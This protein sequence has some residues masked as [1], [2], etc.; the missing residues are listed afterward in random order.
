MRRSIAGIVVQNG[1]IL[2]A[3]RKE[4]G[5]IGLRW[6]FPG[7]KV[8]SGEGDEEA[9]RREFEEE[10]GIR[11]EPVRCLGS[12]SFVSHSGE[13]L[14]T[15][16]LVELPKDC[17]LELREHSM[18]AWLHPQDLRHLDLADSDRSVLPFLEV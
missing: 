16:W 3:K 7:G 11:A 14:L 10:F 4:G 17:I 8:E 5:A 12:A 9:L 13:R 15:A 1:K 6:E 2:V 18:I